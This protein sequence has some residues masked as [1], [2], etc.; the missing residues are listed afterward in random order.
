MV[1]ALQPRALIIENV[2][3]MRVAHARRNVV[4]LQPV[5]ATDRKVSFYDKLVD[6]LS[7][8]GYKVDAMLVNSSEFGVPQKRSRLIAIGVRK[9]LCNWLDGGILRA[10]KLL[11]EEKA[12]PARDLGLRRPSHGIRCDFR[13]R[14][15]QASAGRLHRS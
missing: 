11:D 10:F 14:D 4:E 1:E 9:D 5:D 7:A 3:G 12:R 15:R 8:A 13:P 2:P 6:S